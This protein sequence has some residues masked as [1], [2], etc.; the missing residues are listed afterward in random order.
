MMNDLIM[1][2]IAQPREGL[3]I[4]MIFIFYVTDDEMCDKDSC[5]RRKTLWIFRDRLYSFHRSKLLHAS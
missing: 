2:S 1:C 3:R 5:K 4:V